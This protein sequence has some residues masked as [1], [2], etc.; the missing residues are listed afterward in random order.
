VNPLV[1]TGSAAAVRPLS[2][3]QLYRK[4]DL[5]SLQFG[6]TAEL[7]PIEGLVGQERALEAIRFGN[8]HGAPQRFLRGARG[9]IRTM[10]ASTNPRSSSKMS[11]WISKRQF[12]PKKTSRW[13]GS[14]KTALLILPHSKNEVQFLLAMTLMGYAPV[15]SIRKA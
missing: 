6:T 3:D 7:E 9:I 4:T 11:P 12:L 1:V 15:K 2:I 5:S 8:E 13:R 10:R 14:R